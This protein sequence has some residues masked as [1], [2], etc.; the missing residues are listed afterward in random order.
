MELSEKRKWERAKR[1]FIDAVREDM[2]VGE[3]TK[4]DAKRRKWRWKIHCG[5]HSERRRKKKKVMFWRRRLLMTTADNGDICNLF[6][7]IPVSGL[8]LHYNLP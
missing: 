2:A 3:V 4:E 7:D 8:Y 5:Y 1:R 6:S